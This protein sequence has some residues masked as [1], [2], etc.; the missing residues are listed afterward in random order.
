MDIFAEYALRYAQQGFLVYPL[1]KGTTSPKRGSHAFYD[2]TG[3][4][5]ALAAHAAVHPHDNIAIRTG[6]EGRHTQIDVDAKNGGF[7]TLAAHD[8]EGR[9]LPLDAYYETPSGGFHALFEYCPDLP[10]GAHRLGKGI[11]VVNDKAGVPVPPSVRVDGRY[12]WKA[13]PRNGILPLV[14]AWM[15]EH[16]KADAARREAEARERIKNTAKV[17]PAKVSERDR[18]RYEAFAESILGRA[19]TKISQE[20]AKSRGTALYTHAGFLAP[21]IRNGFISESDVRA[22]LESACRTN[23]LTDKN[24]LKDIHATITRAFAYSNSQLID[25]DKLGDRPYRR[26]A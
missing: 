21:Y 9:A 24:S 23:G 14:P 22:N 20:K 1:A 8:R 5:E 2:A 19:V 25:L 12:I 7:E 10:T 3:D 15:I 26:V 16:V 11:D 6:R 17:D 13:W 4:L 18:G